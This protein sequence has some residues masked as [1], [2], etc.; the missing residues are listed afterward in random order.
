MRMGRTDDEADATV[1]EMRRLTTLGMR[2]VR[3][4]P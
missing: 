3:R 4:T 2:A 1:D